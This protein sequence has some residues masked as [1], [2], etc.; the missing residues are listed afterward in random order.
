[1]S[2]SPVPQYSPGWITVPGKGQRWRTADGTF[3]LQRPAGDVVMALAQKTLDLAGEGPESSWETNIPDVQR[4]SL[5]KG[6]T[7]GFAPHAVVGAAMEAAA[8]PAAQWLGQQAGRSL[9]SLY[10]QG[11]AH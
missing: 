6:V 10:F 7:R 4:I 9:R 2:A 5:R 8:V 3:M 1:M 11:P